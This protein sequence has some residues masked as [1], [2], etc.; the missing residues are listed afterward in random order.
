MM[1]W[2]TGWPASTCHGSQTDRLTPSESTT[3]TT[4][5]VPKNQ[6]LRSL[7]H[8]TSPITATAAMP[9]PTYW[10]DRVGPW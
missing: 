2:K 9:N 8:T 3:E 7:R 5:I 6:S 10:P 4:V 1:F